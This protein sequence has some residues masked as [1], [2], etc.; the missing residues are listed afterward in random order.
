MKGA[1]LAGAVILTI[2]SA[3]FPSD[4]KGTVSTID[5]NGGAFEVCGV[6]VVT[7]QDWTIIEDRLKRAASL[8]DLAEGDYVEIEGRFIEPAKLEATQITLG[9][10]IASGPT[11]EIIDEDDMR[12]AAVT[13]PE[14]AAA[15]AAPEPERI[16]EPRKPAPPKPAAGPPP[17]PAAEKVAGTLRNA[18]AKTRILIVNGTIVNLEPGARVFGANKAPLSL[19]KLKRGC[20][21][22]CEGTKR[23][24][25]EFSARTVRVVK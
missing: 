2:S 13:A 14:E 7:S 9:R 19:S 1:L 3:A 18:D 17:P 22:E 5:I 4:I 6:E 12:E 24:K 8:S 21:V 10:V 15:E 20:R 11:A 25:K 23:S 16:E